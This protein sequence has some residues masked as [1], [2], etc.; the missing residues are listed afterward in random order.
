MCRPP[1]AQQQNFTH[2]ENPVWG[3]AT[4][5]DYYLEI[6]GCQFNQTT[7]VDSVEWQPPSTEKTWSLPVASRATPTDCQAP[8]IRLGQQ[9]HPPKK[10]TLN[11]P[12]DNRDSDI[13]FEDEEYF[14]LSELKSLWHISGNTKEDWHKQHFRT[15]K[16]NL[17]KT[18]SCTRFL[19]AHAMI[20]YFMDYPYSF[21]TFV[22][23]PRKAST[24]IMDDRSIT[25]Y[26]SIKAYF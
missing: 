18:T 4:D 10:V 15:I 25:P 20:V 22:T 8:S 3:N 21:K 13:F 26:M 1:I 11:E 7:Q 24:K 14:P 23:R 2:F 19:A 9:S 16:H 5:D 17:T 6:I 12:E